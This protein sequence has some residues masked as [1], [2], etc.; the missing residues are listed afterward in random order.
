MKKTKA[1][2]KDDMDERL[3]QTMMS[4]SKELGVLNGNMA[5]VL[6]QLTQ[7]N[8]RIQALEEIHKDD[9]GKGGWREDI[10]KMLV[11]CVMIG[12]TALATLVGVKNINPNG[13]IQTAPAVIQSA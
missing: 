4:I 13:I 1:E 7:H 8:Q 9:G 5:G 10:I 12:A 2:G 3:L 6:T 11:K